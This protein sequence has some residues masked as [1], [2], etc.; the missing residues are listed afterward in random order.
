MRLRFQIV[1][2]PL[3]NPTKHLQVSTWATG[4]DHAVARPPCQSADAQRQFDCFTFCERLSAQ[5]APCLL[6][7]AQGATGPAQPELN[8][9]LRERA[10]VPA[11]A[12]KIKLLP[13][14]CVAGADG[15]FQAT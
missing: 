15:G 13:S 10:T 12:P 7:P 9:S 3:L 5:S 6:I 8:W 1:H 14:V 4:Q 2:V 11:A